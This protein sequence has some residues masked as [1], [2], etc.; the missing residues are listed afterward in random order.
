MTTVMPGVQTSTVAVT[1]EPARAWTLAAVAGALL[2]IVGAVLAVIGGSSIGS[3]DAW[4]VAAAIGVWAAG[5]VLLA[6]RRPSWPLAG[7]VGLVALFAGIALALTDRAA[8]SAG[9]GDGRA[10]A[11]T[12]TLAAVFQIAVSVPGRPTFPPAL[13]VGRRGLPGRGR[14]RVRSRRRRPCRAG[15][16]AGRTGPRTGRRRGGRGR[17]GL[18]ARDGAR[19]GAPAV[20]GLGG[21]GD[22]RRRVGGVGVVGTD[23]LARARARRRRRHVGERS[24]G[25]G[26]LDD[27]AGPR[28]RRPGPRP[29]DHRDWHVGPRH[30]GV[31]AGRGRVPRAAGG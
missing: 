3:G 18:P 22:R 17:Q 15:G 26:G 23:R 21:L 12:A 20:G 1:A 25:A 7:A 6:V 19:S 27:R 24:G 2:G 16:A 9:A 31:R 29:H 11:P 4:L 28:A 5:A 30:R 14:R 8:E 13:G 10:F